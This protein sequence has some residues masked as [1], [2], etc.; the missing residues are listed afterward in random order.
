MFIGERILRLRKY[1]GLTQA[2]FA[3]ELKVN[4]SHI[5]HIENK[6]GTPSEMLISL[7]SLK[8]GVSVSWLKTGQGEMFIPLKDALKNQIARFGEQTILDTISNLIEEYD[9][10]TPTPFVK[11]P[12][13]PYTANPELKR[14]YNILHLL[15]SSGDE[16]FKNWVSVQFDRAFPQDV[17]EEAKKKTNGVLGAGLRQLISNY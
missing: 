16:R 4:R 7:I 2:G 11:E 17:I 5:G 12:Q 15:W 1:L 10:S 13:T 9:V 8:F 3:E 6:T 14:M